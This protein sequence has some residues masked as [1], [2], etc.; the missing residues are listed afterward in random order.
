MAVDYLAQLQM[1]PPIVPLATPERQPLTFNLTNM[2]GAAETIVT[3]TSD[4]NLYPDKPVTPE[5]EAAL[6]GVPTPDGTG[7]KVTQWIVGAP[8]TRK[9]LYRV[10]INAVTSLGRTCSPYV[11]VQVAFY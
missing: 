8:L 6:D 5:E 2:L 7:K 11:T 10:N 9:K 1:D 3:V 4:L